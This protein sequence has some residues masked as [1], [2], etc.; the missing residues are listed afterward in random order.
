MAPLSRCRSGHAVLS[1]G[2]L[3]SDMSVDWTAYGVRSLLR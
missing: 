1:T 3:S 2:S